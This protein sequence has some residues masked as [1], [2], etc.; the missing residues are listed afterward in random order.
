MDRMCTVLLLLLKRPWY[1]SN[2]YFSSYTFPPGPTEDRDPLKQ[3]QTSETDSYLLLGGNY[4]WLCYGVCWYLKQSKV[5]LWN[6][7]MPVLLLHANTAAVRGAN[8]TN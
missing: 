8:K 1:K 7:K 6:N 3:G 5:L 2:Y 4:T